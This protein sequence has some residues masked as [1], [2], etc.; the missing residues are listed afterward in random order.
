[1]SL[2]PRNLPRICVALGYQTASELSAAAERECKDGSSFF[3]FRLDALTDAATGIAVI[4]DFLKQHPETRILATCRAKGNG[5]SFTA[6]V[7]KQVDILQV[8]AKAGACAIDLE[9]ESAEAL[10]RDVQKLRDEA[11][12]II[13]FHNF[14]STPALESIL[15]RLRR[16]PADAYK[17]AVT[18]RKPSDNLRLITFARSHADVPLIGLAMSDL[19]TVSRLLAPSLGFLFTY[20]APADHE[21]TAP[22]QIPARTMRNLYRVEKLSKQARIFGVIADPVA[23]SK[24]PLL[25][26]RAFQ[27]RRIDA[28]YLPIRVCGPHLGEWMKLAVALPVAGF[29]VTIPHKQKILRYL[30]YIDPVARRI[31]AVN[32]VWRKAGK[33]R[34]TN[35]DVPGIIRPLQERLRLAHAKVL[36]AGY[37]GAA[38]AAAYAL[39]DAGAELTVTGRDAVRAQSLASVVGAKALPISSLNGHGYDLVINATSVGMFP[40]VEQSVFGDHLPKAQVVFDMVYNPQ[41]T[42]L[43]RHARSQGSEVVPGTE[44]FL[45]QAAQQFE[46]WTGESAPRSVMQQTLEQQLV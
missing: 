24:S 46:I 35:T 17:I 20:G 19:G 14:D 41:E 28:V 27:A 44:M 25:H 30:N 7:A 23:H 18:A 8:A 22:G 34:G 43:L 40:N 9:I 1:M 38:R 21:G 12:L 15:K 33:W 39:A 37:G 10:K 6:G 42:M 31:G 3:E 36:L 16:I 11:P 45:E 26:N 4:S 29:S 13:S 32:T 2:L 5:G